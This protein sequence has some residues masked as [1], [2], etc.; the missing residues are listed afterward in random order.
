[1]TYVSGALVIFRVKAILDVWNC[2]ER[3]FFDFGFRYFDD[4]V[5]GVQMWNKGWVYKAYPIVMGKHRLSVTFRRTSPMGAYLSLR[6]TLLFNYITNSRYKQYIPLFA[7]R[8]A[9]S[10]VPR[11]GIGTLNVLIYAFRD[12][13]KLKKMLKGY[14]LDLYKAPIIR[15]DLMDTIQLLGLRRRFTFKVNKKL[16]KLMDIDENLL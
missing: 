13:K 6:N 16:L 8:D 5:L 9:M 3:L 10:R 12:Y 7:L 4:N 2:W 1:V 11:G 14:R 15:I